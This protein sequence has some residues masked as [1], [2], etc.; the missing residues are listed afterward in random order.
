MR[1]PL[2]YKPGIQRDG[3]DFQDEYRHVGEKL[4][5]EYIKNFK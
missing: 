3:T 4:G 2:V 1:V 5:E